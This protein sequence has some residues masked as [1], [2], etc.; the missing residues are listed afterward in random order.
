MA[1]YRAPLADYAFLIDRFL[2][3]D[4]YRHLPGYAELNSDT[5]TAILEEAAAFCEQVLLPLNQPGDIEGCRFENGRV[6]T[7]RGFASAYSRLV[8]GGWPSLPFDPAY[9]GQGLPHLMSAPISEMMAS[10]NMGFSGYVDIT[11]AAATA[12]H[13]HG[14][15]W[16]KRVFLPPLVSGRWS[17]T[18]NLTEAHA[19][20]DIELMRTRAE[21]ASDGTYGITGAK[22]FITGVDHDLTENIV[23]LVLARIPGGPAGTKG[24]SLFIVPKFLVAEDGSL[25]RRNAI[26]IIGLEH[27]MGVRASATCAV[28]YENAV[29][30]LVG[31]PHDGLRSMFTM[32]NDTQLG[33]GIQGLAI[34]EV[35]TQNARAYA[36]ERL[37]GRAPAGPAAPDRPADPIIHHPDVRRMLSVAEAFNQSARALALWTGHQIDIARHGADAEARQAAD[38]LV[39]LL[40]PAIKAHFT[41]CGFDN[42]NLA[43]QCFGGHGYIRELGMEQFVRDCRITQ[44]YEGANGVQAMDLIGRKLTLADGRLPARFFALIEQDLTAAACAGAMVSAMADSLRAALD[45]LRRL[46]AWIQEMGPSERER[47]AAGSSDYLRLFGMVALGWTWLKIAA[48]AANSPPDDAFLRQKL[49]LANFYLK[50]LAPEAAMLAERAALGDCLPRV[51]DFLKPADA[52]PA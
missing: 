15:D 16:Q 31:N 43:L 19:G 26:T 32:M 18:M 34:S 13:A 41:D 25:G 8:E 52:V 1:I 10:A 21:P 9:G 7:P 47:I 35:A 44:I 29:G 23:N 30:Y 36:V 39:A 22:I 24:V 14:D 51:T 45:R 37:Q 38:D 42:A 49:A 27:K 6:R 4:R 12:I 33:V 2:E 50:R 3:A 5:R 28:N 48:I 40:T 20:T 11:Q 17:G 46:T